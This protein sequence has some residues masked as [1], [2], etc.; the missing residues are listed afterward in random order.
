MPISWN[1]IRHN[2]H[3]FTKEWRDES[4]EEP[5]A[6]S[7]WNEF[8]TVFGVRRRTVASFEE[9]V[10]KLSG[11]WGYI[12]LF[13]PGTLLVEH[14]SLG[15]SLDKANSQAMEYIHG[16]KNDGREEEIPRYIVVSDFARFV[17]HDLEEDKSIAFDLNDFHKNIH[18][19][20]FIPG[21]T[22]A[23]LTAEDPINIKAVELLGDL[24]DTL[25]TDGYSGHDLERFLVRVLFCLF[26]DKT[27]IFERDAFGLYIEHHT[28]ADG[29]DLGI[30]LERFFR[31]LD[32]EPSKR[33]TNLLE[34][35]ADLPHV[36]S[37]LFRER[38][39]FAEFQRA[40]RDQLI[41]CTR[42]D[43][44]RISLAVFG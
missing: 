9:P 36:N 17:L 30:H 1:E 28:R 14:K 42:F 15:K 5:E 25:E 39:D 34:D 20:A 31:V 38:L 22:Q 23:K 24:H 35:L 10:K 41:R 32:T 26:A 21:Y 2:A 3:A 13:W 4:R 11:S 6:K 16:L 40:M 12:D 43:W 8:F 33:Q 19:F 7:F 18:A 27:G 44:S 37:E 29:S